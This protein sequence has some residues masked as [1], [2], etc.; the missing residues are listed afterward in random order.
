MNNH[1]ILTIRPTQKE[2]DETV[3]LLKNYDWSKFFDKWLMTEERTGLDQPFSHLHIA[4]Q[5]RSQYQKPRDGLRKD[6]IGRNRDLPKYAENTIA[7]NLAIKKDDTSFIN[8]CAYC[9]KDCKKVLVV[10]ELS[11]NAE[12]LNKEPLGREIAFHNI[13]DIDRRNI[14]EAVK[15]YKAKLKLG[16]EEGFNVTSLSKYIPLLYKEWLT[17]EYQP[18]MEQSRI[19]TAKTRLARKGIFTMNKHDN[20]VLAFEQYRLFKEP[21]S[22][23]N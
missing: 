7:Y 5:L 17:V 8:S 2:Y 22:N 21:E 16:K 10:S 13:S 23:E 4:F 11:E 1:G 3:N 18:Y 20:V 12:L 9:Y 19:A 15:E 6:L 14:D